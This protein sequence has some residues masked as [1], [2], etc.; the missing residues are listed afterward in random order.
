MGMQ[1]GGGEGGVKSEP[2]VVPMIDIMLVLL[3]IFM[4]VTPVISSGF[5][6]QMPL[7]KNVEA[8]PDD[9]EDI[10]LGMD[11][12]GNFYLDPGTGETHPVREAEL[13]DVLRQIFDSRTKDKIMYFRA[14][15][16]LRFGRVQDAIETARA[17]GVR[18]LAT[19]I[20]ERRD[21]DSGILGGGGR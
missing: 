20:D 17:A 8:R 14:D 1:V 5:Q 16:G 7:G 21:E 18:V 3:I 19:V 10:V 9:P 4:I 6:A 11:S 13:E 2:N 12:E 15:K